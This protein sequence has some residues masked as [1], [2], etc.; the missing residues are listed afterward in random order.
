MRCLLSLTV[1]RVISWQKSACN[2]YNHRSFLFSMLS[3]VEATHECPSNTL[4]ISGHAAPCLH[5][6]FCHRRPRRAA[7]QRRL[8]L[9]RNG[10]ERMRGVRN[11]VTTG[12]ETREKGRNDRD[13]RLLQRFAAV[14]GFVYV[15]L[16]L[17]GPLRAPPWQSQRSRWQM[18]RAFLAQLTLF[19]SILTH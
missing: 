15:Q 4:C 1:C 7:K 9:N 11:Y 8:R 5:G 16:N 3:G 13:V 19:L 14:A 12:S 18:T 10:N 17:P 2:E 6:L